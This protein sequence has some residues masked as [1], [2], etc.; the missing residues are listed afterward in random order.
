MSTFI[1]VTGGYDTT[2]RFFDA[3]TQTIIRSLQFHDQ[4]VLRLSFSGNG[5]VAADEPLFLAVAGA[6]R[7]AIFDVTTDDS[8]PNAF[9][10]YDRH[11]QPV[12]AVGFEPI[13]TAFVYSASEDGTLQTWTPEPTAIPGQPPVP[14]HFHPPPIQSHFAT[15]AKIVNTGPAGVVPIHDAIYYP[16]DDLFFT[17]DYIGRLRVW[18]HATAALRSELIP[19]SSRRN[20]QCLELSSDYTI[21]VIANFDGFVFIYKVPEIIQPN[22][23]HKQAE[24]ANSSANTSN[25]MPRPICFNVHHSYIP[26]VRL[27]VP[28][29]RLVC[30]LNDGSTKVFRMGDILAGNIAQ[31]VTQT[32]AVD[33]CAYNITP[34]REFAGHPGWVWDAAFVGD[35]EDYLFT[36]S[37]NTQVMLWN[38]NQLQHSTEYT[39]HQKAVVCLAVKERMSSTINADQFEV[40]HAVDH[41]IHPPSNQNL[42]LEPVVNEDVDY[43]LPNG[44]RQQSR[45][46]SHNDAT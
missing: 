22:L 45:S 26:R 7:I 33:G 12:T 14:H 27:S 1:L 37:S 5:P 11:T 10:V 13:H 24:L 16:P 38:L 39:G 40:T 34:I 19:H 20:L 32:D 2:I 3:T 9:A 25:P 15:P 17:V 30:T 31:Q 6:T 35:G 4:Q 28:M 41:S 18:E 23:P 43:L 44:S 46:P 42:R 21:L 8:S 36:C 29:N